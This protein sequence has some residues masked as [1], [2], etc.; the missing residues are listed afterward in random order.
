M[1]RIGNAPLQ[2]PAGVTVEVSGSEVSVKGPK[3]QLTQAIVPSVSIQ[4]EDNTVTVQRAGNGKQ[5]RAYHGLMRSLIGN[6][7]EGVT[8]G[9]EKKL[10]IIGVGYRA[11]VKG[12][13]MMETYLLAPGLAVSGDG[14]VGV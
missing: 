12:K 5:A 9:F 6:M 2:I 7:V 1:S 13:G 8:A 4:V 14:L 3:G 11:E 10:E